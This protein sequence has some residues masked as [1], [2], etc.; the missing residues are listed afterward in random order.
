MGETLQFFFFLSDQ[1]HFKAQVIYARKLGS[2]ARIP[3]KHI[4]Q[5]INNNIFFTVKMVGGL[6]FEVGIIVDHPT[7]I[8]EQ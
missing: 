4:F 6:A 5:W 1:S 8:P 7:P 2:E 3:N